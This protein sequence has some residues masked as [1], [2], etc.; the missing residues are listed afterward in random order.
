MKTKLEYDYQFS[1]ET[2]DDMKKAQQWIEDLVEKAGIRGDQR[3]FW[4]HAFIQGRE[5][6]TDSLEALEMAASG[7]DD[8]FCENVW[9]F[10]RKQSNMSAHTRIML[11]KRD[12]GVHCRI[13]SESQDLLGKLESITTVA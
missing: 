1:M 11:N 7:K 2:L 8:V 3:G 9:C 12:G 10:I 5:T 4:F 13:V 6:E